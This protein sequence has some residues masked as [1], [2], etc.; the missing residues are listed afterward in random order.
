MTDLRY[1]DVEAALAR[2][3][4]IDED[5]IAALRARIRHLRNI[6]VPD[7]PKVGTGT[8]ITY[9]RAHAIELMFA[10]HLAQFGVAPRW[11]QQFVQDQFGKL[12]EGAARADDDDTYLFIH[13][14]HLIPKAS[15]AGRGYAFAIRGRQKM[16]AH[17][18]KMKVHS[19]TVINL[20]EM[21]RSLDAALSAATR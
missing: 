6:G 19:W 18:P 9:T 8:Q 1:R 16:L 4:A 21:I 15:D 7:L 14:T 11:F 10:L 2:V 13:P 17:I 20:S 3:F 12:I 5:Q